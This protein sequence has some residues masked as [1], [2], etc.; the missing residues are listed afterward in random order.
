MVLI[1]WLERGLGQIL[2][3]DQNYIPDPDS[4]DTRS[5]F[6]R[7][8]APDP[9]FDTNNNNGDDGVS[10]VAGTPKGSNANIGFMSP[11][12]TPMSSSVS[13]LRIDEN[14][15]IL[16]TPS[17][18]YYRNTNR[19]NITSTTTCSD[20]NDDD[21]DD[22]VDSRVLF[23][24]KSLAHCMAS[25]VSTR[26]KADILFRYCAS[27]IPLNEAN[28]RKFKKLLVA[29]ITLL[30]ARCSRMGHLCPDGYT[31]MMA[32]AH[33]NHV[34]AA[35]ILWDHGPVDQLKETNLQGKTP[36]HIA[37]ENG[38]MEILEFLQSK[39]QESYG[40][41]SPPP[42]DLIGM[43][44][45]GVA[46]TSP[47]PNAI[48]NKQALYDKLFSPKD[49]SIMGSPAPVQQRVT[50][51]RSLQIAYSVSQMPG[52]RIF[53]ED[54]SVASAWDTAALFAVCD[55]HSD[56]GQVSKFV[57][58]SFPSKF[59][60]SMKQ[61][62]QSSSASLD[63]TTM[64]TEI[65]LST[66]SRLK[67]VNIPGGSTAVIAVVTKNEIICANVGD[68][69]CIL[70]QNS[71]DD[72]TTESA[73]EESAT[74]QQP[75]ENVNE[76]GGDVNNDKIINP[77]PAAKAGTET[78]YIV[79]PLSDDHKANTD[80]EIQ[81]I[82]KA[83]LQVV[84]D[85]FVEDSKEVRISKVALSDK[86]KMACSRSFGD[87][88]YKSNTSL[89]DTEQAIVAVP[90]VIIRQR[91]SEK[92]DSFLVLACDGIWDVMSNDDVAKFVVETMNQ[93]CCEWNTT[94][95]PVTTMSLATVLP[96]VGDKLLAE[97]FQR[98]SNDNLSCIIVSL[99]TK[100]I[101]QMGLF[102]QSNKNIQGKALDF[103]TP[104]VHTI[105]AEK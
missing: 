28:Q 45:L 3:P 73:T 87:F 33:A 21:D 83:G 90:D 48:K 14:R 46:V 72:V 30:E 104:A 41:N 7:F 101:E 60:Q 66:D 16:M 38:H 43:T 47:L 54:S 13:S 17:P 100:L 63:W 11:S 81:R 102:S 50:Y 76:S 15:N 80:I 82:E 68:C 6:W 98:G 31:P 71:S 89:E 92:K 53:M 24:A 103:T 34:V 12:K 59:Q 8:V 49:V 29:D 56:S 9:N 51:S 70:I 97:C 44:P 55:G 91:C 27:S 37:A 57:A 1:Q 23:A 40:L 95:S 67:D 75:D 78:N 77:S 22:N 36:Y 35:Q 69:R 79:I 99:N 65:C 4:V 105:P 42:I 18:G 84:E 10:V 96:I 2:A 86:N 58:E 26:K 88:E 74:K 32:A 64:C 19:N 94:N 5:G 61:Q 85:V 93:I 39:Y 62:Q 20:N 52:K 25:P